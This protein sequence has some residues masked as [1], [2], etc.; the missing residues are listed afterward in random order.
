MSNFF[1]N[2]LYIEK[3]IKENVK[4]YDLEIGEEPYKKKWGVIEK[5]TKYYAI[6]TKKLAEYLEIKE[7]VEM[8]P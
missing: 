4:Y 6:L 3:A 2:I 5:P 7:Y 1:W 8:S